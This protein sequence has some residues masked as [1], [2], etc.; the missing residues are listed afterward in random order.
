M[1]HDLGAFLYM[2]TNITKNSQKTLEVNFSRRTWGGTGEAALTW[3]A[4]LMMAAINRCVRRTRA[5]Y[6][7]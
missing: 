4:E 7:R 6:H 2:L 1:E 3:S 5:E